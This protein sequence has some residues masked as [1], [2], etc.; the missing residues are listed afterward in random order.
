MSNQWELCELCHRRHSVSEP[1]KRKPYT[2]NI[3]LALERQRLREIVTLVRLNQ[4]V[5]S[6]QLLSDGCNAQ[7]FAVE[8]V[9]AKRLKKQCESLRF[10]QANKVKAK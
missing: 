4:R 1:G 5:S 7:K 3:T 6:A 8:Y 9:I 10:R 2:E